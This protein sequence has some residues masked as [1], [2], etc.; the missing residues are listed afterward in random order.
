MLLIGKFTHKFEF[1][2]YDYSSSVLIS[3][4]EFKKFRLIIDWMLKVYQHEG[5][6]GSTIQLNARQP[7]TVMNI[8]NDPLPGPFQ[9]LVEDNQEVFVKNNKTL[10]LIQTE[11]CHIRLTHDT[12]I[13]L[14]PVL[15]HT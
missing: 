1:L 10:G 4:K 9:R 11:K 8:G 5:K 14:R 3:I 13:N 2:L 7:E 12:P 6:N 15:E